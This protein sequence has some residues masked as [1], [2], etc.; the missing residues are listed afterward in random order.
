QI[1]FPRVLYL[2]SNKDAATPAAKDIKAMLLGKL[3]DWL[4]NKNDRKQLEMAI[5]LLAYE[6][7][8]ENNG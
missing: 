3:Y 6:H 1:N 8:G 5:I 4:K 7:R 2:L